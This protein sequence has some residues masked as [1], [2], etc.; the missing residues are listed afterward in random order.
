MIQRLL[1]LSVVCIA[2]ASCA[3]R[4][5]GGYY[6]DDGPPDHVPIDVAKLQDPVPRYE[7]RS[8]RGND[9]YKALGRW[10][11]PLKSAQGYWE[12]GAASWYGK[13][14]HGK[15][16]SSGEVYDMFAMTAAH[17]TLPL[18]TYVRVVNLNNGRSVTV[19]VNDRGPF[20]HNRLIDLSYAAAYKLGIIGTGTGLVEISSVAP[21]GFEAK[22]A[23]MNRTPVRDVA[24]DAP[25]LFLQLG[26][27][28]GRGNAER[29]QARLRAQ[30]YEPAV[31][32]IRKNGLIL[33]R[34]R[35]GPLKAISDADQLDASL[36][37]LGFD[38]QL[39][40]E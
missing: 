33:H 18:P 39:V 26:A 10:Y 15:R 22:P 13:K 38:S 23:S 7:P 30:G 6:A 14:F 24:F 40:V 5:G 27:F 20:L 36:R 16:T 12:R 19:R 1:L 21:A 11:Y 32:S 2:I 29:L 31:D 17:R 4:R 28:A 35:I 34:V 25:R 8:A 9:P 3:T 37:G